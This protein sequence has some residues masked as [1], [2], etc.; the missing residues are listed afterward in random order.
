M[1]RSI[2]QYAN[3]EK[4]AYI[5]CPNLALSSSPKLSILK[6]LGKKSKVNSKGKR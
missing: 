6:E 5:S 1:A 3:L 4:Y 2:S